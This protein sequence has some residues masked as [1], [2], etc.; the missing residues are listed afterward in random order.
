M[1]EGAPGGH[2]HH[3]RAEADRRGGRAEPEPAPRAAGL[4][5]FG[6]RRREHEADD[7]ARGGRLAA[8]RHARVQ[9][10]GRDERGEEEAG[11]AHGP[12][13]ATVAPMAQFHF[14]P[15]TYRELMAAEVPAFERLQDEVTEASRGPAPARTV[16]ELG[17]G[18]GETARRVLAAHPDARLVGL[19][20]SERMLAVAREALPEADLRV[21]RL[22]GSAAPRP[23]RPRRL[24]AL[25]PPRRRPRQGRPLRPGRGRPRAGRAPRR[26]RRRRP[27]PRGRRHHPDRW[28]H[29]PAEHGRRAAGLAGGRGA[30]AL[31][32]VGASGPRRPRR[33]RAAAHRDVELAPPRH[34]GAAGPRAVALALDL[35]EDLAVHPGRRRTAAWPCAQ[36]RDPGQPLVVAGVGA[37]RSGRAAAGSRAPGPTRRAEALGRLAREVEAAAPRRP[38]RCRAGCSSA[39]SPCP[40][41]AA[42]AAARASSSS[43]AATA[44]TTPTVP[45]DPV[46][47]GVELRP[48]W[49]ARAPLEVPRMPRA[50]L[51]DGRR[52]AAAWRAARSSSTRVSRGCAAR[53]PAAQSATR[54]DPLGRVRACR[55]RRGRRACGRRGRGR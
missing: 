19:D 8:G 30:P 40:S 6:H 47:V 34:D 12:A 15:A 43:R 29:R 32:D 11:G 35:A 44:I 5:R 46:A 28:R 4:D 27:A 9:D 18:T 25:R 17:T 2:A 48:R 55:R 45:G 54:R 14:D 16:L 36:Q 51:A 31:P 7:A 24:R 22:E 13:Q 3:L 23:V 1:A 39:A 53:R 37:W 42:L 26:R 49:P 33:L 38:R 52:A 10:L 41:A 50:E 21:G 20:A